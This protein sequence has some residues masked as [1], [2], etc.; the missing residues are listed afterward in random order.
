M[1]TM[2]CCQ[3]TKIVFFDR[4]VYS[5]VFEVKMSDS[6]SDSD[7]L[8]NDLEEAWQEG[9]SAIIPEKSK[10]RYEQTYKIFKKWLEA[11]KIA[12]HE[13]GLL[14]YFVVRSGQLKS[15]GS[16]WAEY[17]MLKSTIFLYDAIDISKFASLIAYLKRKNIGYR[18]KKAKVFTKEDMEKFLNEA[19][20]EQFLVQKVSL[21][22]D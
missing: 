15:P 5:S 20:D 22:D 10:V 12:L 4:F 13:K 2:V 18:P 6:D 16:L 14:A 21:D 17:S 9:C 19:P 3:T 11:K 7:N 8:P 1:V